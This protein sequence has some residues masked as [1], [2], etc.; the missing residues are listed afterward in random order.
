MMSRGEI[1]IIHYDV[2][3]YTHCL[4]DIDGKNDTSKSIYFVTSTMTK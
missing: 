1:N 3:V 2:M 4:Q